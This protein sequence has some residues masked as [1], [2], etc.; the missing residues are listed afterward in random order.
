VDFLKELRKRRVITTTL[1]YMVASV[2]LVVG[3]EVV[4]EAM[5]ASPNLVNTVAF[6]LLGGAPVVVALA[7]M[8]DITPEGVEHTASKNVKVSWKKVGLPLLAAALLLFIALSFYSLNRTEQELK[9]APS[10]TVVR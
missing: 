10:P 5:G 9:P 4:G 2:I 6:I 1:I 8:F 7:W 3:V